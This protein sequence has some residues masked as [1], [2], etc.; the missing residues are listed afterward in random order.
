MPEHP[1]VAPPITT[2]NELLEKYEVFFLDAYGVLIDGASSLPFASQFLNELNARGKTY[3]VVTNDSVRLPETAA[4]F[5]AEKGV[6]VPSEK[7]LSAGRC[8][9]DLFRQQGLI[10]KKC[11]VAGSVDTHEYVRR[12]GGLPIAIDPDFD[13]PAV[14][15]GSDAGL[16]TVQTFNDLLSSIHRLIELARPP[17]LILPNSD[18]IYPRGGQKFGITSGAIA[19]LLEHALRVLHPAQPPTFLRIG[20]PNRPLFD[21]ALAEVGAKGPA[22]MLGDQI[23]TDILGA[24]R[25]G[26]D[27]ALLLTGLT[28]ELPSK[29]A[30]ADERPT[31]ILP[32]LQLHP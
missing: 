22:I 11:A 1:S 19:D 8:L 15:V 23:A 31:W 27:S 24:N 29:F 20:K 25:A 17:L 30:H 14:V 26:I 12:A 13:A 2:A 7:I 3:L 4:R 9:E 21:R 10:N 5:Y 18:I 6:V 16:A 28:R 32:S